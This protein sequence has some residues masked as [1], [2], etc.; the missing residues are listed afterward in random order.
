[1][2]GGKR[3]I[4]WTV[5]ALVVACA[6]LLPHVRL[7]LCPPASTHIIQAAWVNVTPALLSE[8]APIVID[9]RVVD[10]RDIARTALSWQHVWSSPVERCEGGESITDASRSC[11]SKTPSS[12]ARCRY[13]TATPPPR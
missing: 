6:V 12:E 4:G 11:S 9:D 2:K 7:Y 1:M 3:Y 10:L 5:A 8:R 13:A